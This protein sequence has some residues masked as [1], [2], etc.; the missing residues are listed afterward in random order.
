[1]A[2]ILDFFTPEA[3]QRRTRALNQL[4]DDLT[5]YIPPELRRLAP[6]LGLLE[7]SDA[8]DVVAMRE[9]GN[10]FYDEPSVTNAIQ[11]G[12]AGVGAALPVISSRM[13]SEGVDVFGDAVNSL[14][15]DAGR[16]FRD[17]VDRLNQPGEMPT[18]YANP[19][20]G[21][22]VTKQDLDPQGYGS[23]RLDDYL[24]NTNLGLTDLGENLPRT[25]ASYE[26]LEGGYV[27]PLYGDRTSRGFN[28]SSINDTEFSRP[29]YTQG[30][31]DFMRGPANQQDNAV[32]ASAQHIID[33]LNN[34]AR[35]TVDADMAAGIDRPVFGVTGSMAPDAVDFADFTGAAAAE[36]VGGARSLI[37]PSAARSFDERLGSVDPTFPGLLSDNLRDWA[38]NTTS[39]MRKNFIRGLETKPMRD[40]GV[41]PM[42]LA[43]YGVTD[44][45]LREVGSGQFGSAFAQLDPSAPLLYNAPVGNQYAASVPHSTYNTQMT[46]TYGGELPLVPQGLLFRDAYERMATQLDKRGNPLGEA[47]K[48]YSI[49]TK[50]EPQLMTPQVVDGIM[51]YL[52]SLRG[53]Q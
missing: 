5:Y 14:G 1:M 16:V 7:Y 28:L 3:G 22:R 11:A 12:A 29:V 38:E 10:Q 4:T 36:L 41:P 31:V 20:L 15:D 9:A 40:A 32:W 35:R 18:M 30:G 6:A 13:M 50:L 48:T 51:Q 34:T 21:G 37:D 44:P 46:G 27:L 2:G 19:I 33:R 43:R 53:Q 45:S 24:S 23:T 26:A 17:L 8:G 47:N 25:P 52:E 42:A 39:E 49:K